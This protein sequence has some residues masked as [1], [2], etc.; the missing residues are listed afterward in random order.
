M[1][2]ELFMVESG[3]DT[4]RSNHTDVHLHCVLE[5]VRLG[6]VKLKAIMTN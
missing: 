1:H 4:A 6:K 5:T 3:A 2:A